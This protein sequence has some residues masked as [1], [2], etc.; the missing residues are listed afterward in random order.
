MK[1]MEGGLYSTLK[2]SWVCG[3]LIYALTFETRFWYYSLEFVE[4]I[5]VFNAAII[6]TK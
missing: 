3:I 4:E 5:M 2:K 6:A 1:Q